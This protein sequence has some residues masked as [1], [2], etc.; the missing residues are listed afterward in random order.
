MEK[1]IAAA[2]AQGRRKN[3]LLVIDEVD[4]F[5]MNRDMAERHWEASM[6]NQML[7]EMERGQV[8]FVATT[9]RLLKL[10]PVS[11]R[12]FTIHEQ[13]AALDAARAK[14][15]YS[16]TFGGDA[17]PHLDHLDGLTPGDFTQVVHRA[18]LL[19]EMRSDMIF[20]WLQSALEQRCGGVT[21]I[22]FQTAF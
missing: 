5:L 6:T 22:E 21:R 1:Q 8:R 13:F 12:R 17:P 9:N 11:A 14:K 4:S 7:R 15:L 19:R 2:F 10:D 16:A 20:R 18:H 3:A